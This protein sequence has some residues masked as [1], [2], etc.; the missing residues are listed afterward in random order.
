MLVPLSNLLSSTM[1]FAHIHTH[2]VLEY[3]FSKWVSFRGKGV[4]KHKG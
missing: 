4:K 3:W 1:K 2:I